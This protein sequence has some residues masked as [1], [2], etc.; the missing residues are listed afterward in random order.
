MRKA[1]TLLL[2]VTVSVLTAQAQSA[3]SYVSRTVAGTFPLGDGGPATSAL[4]ELPQA[5]A[6]DSNGTLYIADAGNGLIR[7]VSRGTI[8]SVVGYSGYVYDLKLDAS[9]NLYIAGGNYAYKLTPTG[10]LSIVAGNGS[11][12]TFTGDGGPATSAG[13]SGI[14]GIAI[15]SANNIYICDAYNNRI[16]KVTPDGIVQT[17]AGGGKGFA[18]DNGPASSALFN[19][20]RNIA[21]DSQGN[22]YINDYNNNRVRKISVDNT[23][24][25]IAGS[26][27]CCSSP[28]GGLAT[29]A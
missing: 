5:V 11:T 15:D 22:I 24:K 3:S 27:V 26:G 8:S 12:T 16:R 2:A 23:I 10:K 21:L 14:Y 9:G 28:D 17:I 1:P 4:L 13:F 6:A 7:K 29:A 19:L 20:P 25:T 18:G